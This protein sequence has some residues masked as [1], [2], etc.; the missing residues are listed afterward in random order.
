MKLSA[1]FFTHNE[2]PFLRI[3]IA[4]AM[5]WADQI[6]VLDMASNDGTR[7][8]CETAL[9]HGDVYQRRRTN[10][11]TELGFGEA[12]TAAA[13]LADGDWIVSL[14]ADYILNWADA[15]L[16]RPWL[17]EHS[18]EFTAHKT[19]YVDHYKRDDEASF[20]W[21]MAHQRDQVQGNPLVQHVRIFRND[22]RFSFTGYIHEELCLDGVNYS[23]HAAGAVMSMLHFG[24]LKPKAMARAADTRKYYMM[25]RLIGEPHLRTGINEYW[26][27]AFAQENRDKL[28]Y[29]ARMF[30]A[31][32]TML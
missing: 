5:Q 15:D 11:V 23:S 13:R 24:C 22:P 20:A 26:W 3:S 12:R 16:I 31:G 6:C 14:D 21:E 7:E 8:Y 28:E 19:F 32:R 29:A 30:E 27:T 9:R 17:E 1:C 25:H 4:Y 18:P 10:T 2:L